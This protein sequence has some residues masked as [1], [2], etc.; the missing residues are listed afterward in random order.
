[1][2][3]WFTT[4]K[5]ESEVCRLF[6]KFDSPGKTPGYWH[7]RKKLTGPRERSPRAFLLA[8]IRVCS[9]CG[10]LA[11]APSALQF[12]AAKRIDIVPYLF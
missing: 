11:G 8:G 5:I 7:H 6:V 2:S 1:V 10:R 12:L 9:M 4:A 3:F